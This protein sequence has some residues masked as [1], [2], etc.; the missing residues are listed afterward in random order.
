[1]KL[2]RTC[3]LLSLA[4]VC[5]AFAH[6]QRTTFGQ[7]YCPLAS[8][9]NLLARLGISSD[10]NAPL[11]VHRTQSHSVRQ[12]PPRFICH[13]QRSSA[14]PFTN[15]TVHRTVLPNRTALTL[16]LLELI[17]KSHPYE[18]HKKTQSTLVC[19]LYFLVRRMGLEPTWLPT[20]PSNV[21]VCL[22]RHLR[23]WYFDIL[24]QET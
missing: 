20:R 17:F 18:L 13:R 3:V 9:I 11:F 4:V 2:V 15:E 8:S 7:K 22:F 12:R 21:R 14:L 23:V 6:N 16:V 24:P 5:F 1:M 19:T 10:S